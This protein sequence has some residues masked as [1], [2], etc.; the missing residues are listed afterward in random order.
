VPIAKVRDTGVI[1]DSP[2]EPTLC[3]KEAPM[4]TTTMIDPTPAAPIL[5][6]PN[7]P[8]TWEHPDDPRLF[9]T[10]DRM[11]V[12]APIT[13]MSDVFIRWFCD[14]TNAASQA[15]EMPV[16]LYARRINT[17]HYLAQAPLAPPPG[18]MEAQAA[19]TQARVGAVMARLDELWAT[20]WLPEV[21]RHLAAWEAFDLPGAALPALLAHLEDTIARHRR[22]WE[23]HGRVNTPALMALAAFDDLYQHLFGGEDTLKALRLLQGFDNKTLESGRAL[24]QLSRQALAAPEVRA[25]LETTPPAHVLAALDR[26]PSGRTFRAALQAYLEEYG[27]RSSMF[28]ELATPSWIEE[29]TPVIQ[30]LQGYLTQIDRDPQAERAALAAERERLVAAAR[31]RLKDHAPEVAGQFESLLKAAQAGTVLMEDHAF[32]IDFR[33]M[34]EVRRVLLEFGRRFVAAGVLEQEGDVFYLTIDEL[35][36]T[37]A[38]LPRRDQRRLVAGRR[39]EIAYF[40]TITPPAALGT[41]PQIS[42]DDPIARLAA[43]FFGAPPAEQQPDNVRGSAGS[44]GVARGRARIIQS[45]ADAG[46]LQQGD[47]L[48]APT[49]SPPWTPLFAT[50]AAVVTDTGGVLSHSAIVAREYGIPA[51]VGTGS[52]TAIIRD[53]Q[54]IEVDG[55]AGIVRIMTSE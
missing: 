36:E 49:T 23:I 13:P 25:I 34:Y 7:F 8:V 20:E 6:P 50:V 51:V 30:T 14:A 21:Q 26:S 16:R 12:P 9:W 39:A 2:I 42:A 5:A 24:W 48:V 11:H 3:G 27:R 41:P 45:L 18:E 29:P 40:R 52:A 1:D 53:G 17:Y 46:T 44:A 37:A 10:L 55:S 38:A 22:I 43:K 31:E 47:I 28:V 32:W 35:R 15:Y 54:L 19:R 4:A 33:A